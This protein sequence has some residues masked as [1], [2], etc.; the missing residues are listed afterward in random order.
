MEVRMTLT[1]NEKQFINF[2]IDQTGQTNELYFDDCVNAIYEKNGGW[3]IETLVGIFGS[4]TKKGILHYSR[5]DSEYGRLYYWDMMVY[6]EDVPEEFHIKN[7]DEIETWLNSSNRKTAIELQ[8]NT[9][10]AHA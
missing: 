2:A 7:A 3:N 8:L 9:E 5:T 6:H 1:E 10:V 4:L